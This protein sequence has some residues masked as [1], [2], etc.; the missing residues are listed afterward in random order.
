MNWFSFLKIGICS[1]HLNRCNENK[2]SIWKFGLN[3]EYPHPFPSHVH[4]FSLSLPHSLPSSLSQCVSLNSREGWRTKAVYPFTI[5]E[6]L[7]FSL[8][9]F[10]SLKYK[11][12]IGKMAQWLRALAEDLDSIP[13]T[14]IS[15]FQGICHP[16]WTSVGTYRHVVHT[17]RHIAIYTAK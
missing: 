15:E 7:L 14:H 17:C 4:S 2:N 5:N 6:I 1:V 13:K 11:C 8:S 10:S 12:G 3:N 16:H 9:H